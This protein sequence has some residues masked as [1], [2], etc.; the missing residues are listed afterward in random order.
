MTEHLD[1]AQRLKWDLVRSGVTLARSQ[2][3]A[4]LLLQAI[5]AGD[6]TSWKRFYGAVHGALSEA[7]ALGNT[8]GPAAERLCALLDDDFGSLLF[9]ADERERIRRGVVEDGVREAS[10]SP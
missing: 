8:L 10:L 2:N 6:R 1:A 5:A 3:A 4:D 9:P 7:V